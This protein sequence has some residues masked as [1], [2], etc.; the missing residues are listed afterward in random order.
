M[1]K[2]RSLSVDEIIVQVYYASKVCRI[3]QPHFVNNP[4]PKIDNIVFMGMGEP[5]DNSDSVIRAVNT[6]T[7]RRMF[8]LAQSKI[9]ISTVAPDTKAFETLGQAPAL[10]AFSVHAVRD[11]IRQRLVPSTKVSWSVSSHT[12]KRS[13]STQLLL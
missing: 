10:L 11:S 6:M 8:S 9:T 4:L 1:G 3:V 2:L 7:D 13:F 5:A 12:Y